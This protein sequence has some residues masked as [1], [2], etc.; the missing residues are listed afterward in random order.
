MNK[1]YIVRLTEEERV[2][3]TEF[4]NKGQAAAAK[5]KHA[6]VLLKVDADGPNWC[7]V[8]TAE[9]FSCRART[10]SNLRQ[11]FVEQ[12]LEAALGRKP[13]ER[14]AREPILAGEKEARLIQLVWS[15]PPSR[16]RAVDIAAA[17]RGA[18]VMRA[19]KKNELKPHQRTGWVIPPAQNTAFVANME[20]I[21]EVVVLNM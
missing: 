10:V 19:L 21:L 1:K 2:Q 4:V 9:A 5:I 16:A 8:Q 13:R 12:G 3:L 7:D 17:G 20:D 14:P 15:E 18:T 11:R 6:N